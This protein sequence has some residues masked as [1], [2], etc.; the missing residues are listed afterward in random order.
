MGAS[1]GITLVIILLDQISKNIILQKLAIGESIKII[2]N[3]FYITHIR[4]SGAA[5]GFL[6]DKTW[7]INILTLLSII[8]SLYLIYLIFLNNFIFFRVF[9]SLILGGSIGNL[10]DRVRFGNVVD[11]LS[12]KF[13]NYHFPVFNIADMSIVIG[14]VLLLIYFIFNQDKL[15]NIAFSRN[16]KKDK[17]A[18]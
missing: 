12:F 16:D 14:G 2:N 17:E 6:A 7:G 15:D 11:F 5:W 1:L 8:V 9:L 3:F 18:N 13:G 4:N 10:I